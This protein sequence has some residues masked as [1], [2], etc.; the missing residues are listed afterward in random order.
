LS[1]LSKR[2]GGLRKIGQDKEKYGKPLVIVLNE[3]TAMPGK[4]EWFE[5]DRVHCAM[6]LTRGIAVYPAESAARP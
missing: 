1:R 4:S 5:A 6:Y 3:E 2:A